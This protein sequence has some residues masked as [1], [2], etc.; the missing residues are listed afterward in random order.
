MNTKVIFEVEVPEVIFPGFYNTEFD[1]DSVLDIEEYS[2]NDYFEIYK[3]YQKNVI[4]DII[5]HY[6]K[7]LPNAFKIID[8]QMWSPKEYNYQNDKIYLQ[9]ECD[10]SDILYHFFKYKHENLIE[11]LDLDKYH[12]DKYHEAM[13]EVL[14]EFWPLDI[15]DYDEITLKEKFIY[16]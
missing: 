16:G 15:K 14:L 12:E 1:P 5:E 10:F 13:L 11:Y 8:Y 7:A 9:I 6:K 4:N 3:Q 2:D